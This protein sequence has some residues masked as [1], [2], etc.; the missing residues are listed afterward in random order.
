M[1]TQKRL[2][3]LTE[4]PKMPRA[5]PD[6]PQVLMLLQ[7]AAERS[8]VLRAELHIYAYP[9]ALPA[10]SVLPRPRA[11]G[12][13]HSGPD[14]PGS[15]HELVYRVAYATGLGGSRWWYS[16]SSTAGASGEH[17]GLVF[18]PP[19]DGES[20]GYALCDGHRTWTVS[21][22]QV[23]IEPAGPAGIPLDELLDPSWL[24]SRHNIVIED[25]ETV[26]GRPGV[27]IRAV[28]RRLPAT[29]P[30]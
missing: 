11:P 12:Q 14:A 16:P 26:D 29:N 21:P 24:L 25:V 18:P 28:P 13:R 8:Y 2:M 20:G 30:G 1:R 5:V 6:R 9:S 19:G 17:P 10:G 15:P 3:Q 22:D 23:V 4:I 27:R 7:A